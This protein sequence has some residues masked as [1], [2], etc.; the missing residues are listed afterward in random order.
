MREKHVLV[1][2]DDASIRDLVGDYLSDHA[3]R[4]SRAADGSAMERT[5]SRVSPD[6][7]LL[8]LQLGNEDGLDLLR[9]VASRA[10]TPVIIITG[11]RRDEADRVVGLELGADDYITK[12]FG[13]RELLARVRAVLRRAEAGNAAARRR[14]DR[15]VYRFAGWELSMRARRLKAPGGEEVKL[16]AAEFNLLSAF[17]RAPQTVLSREQLLNASRVHDDEVYDRCI[18]VLI[19]RLRRKLEP[20][21]SLPT[22][23]TTERGMGYVLAA[24]VEVI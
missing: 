21:P 11:N 19:L 14:A 23:I 7:I 13:L 5:L 9:T 16:T 12:P 22:L 4:V 20:D 6:V 2:D 1:V 15:S 3:F 10:D 24:N 17:L 8:D 18:D